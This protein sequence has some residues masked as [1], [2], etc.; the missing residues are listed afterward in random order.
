MLADQTRTEKAVLL[1]CGRHYVVPETTL[2]Q[3]CVCVVTAV[4]TAVQALRVLPCKALCEATCQV[5]DG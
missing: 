1:V 4:L 2:R 3:H 5:E